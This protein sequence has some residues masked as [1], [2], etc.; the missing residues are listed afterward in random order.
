MLITLQIG[1]TCEDLVMSVVY[2]LYQSPFLNY[3]QIILILLCWCMLC[4]SICV[5]LANTVLINT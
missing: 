3:L 5:L 2:Y 1:L 4:Y